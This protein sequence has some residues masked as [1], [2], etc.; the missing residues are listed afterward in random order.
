MKQHKKRWAAH[1]IIALLAMFV[2]YA[3]TR[4]Q[5]LPNDATGTWLELVSDNALSKKWSIP[6]VGVLRQYDLGHDTEFAFL[7]TGATYTLPNAN[8]KATLGAAYL[9]NLPFDQELFRPEQYQFWVY[10]ELTIINAD[11]WSQRFRLEHR[12]IHDTERIYIGHRLRYRLQF[13]STFAHNFYFKCF[14]EP[15]FNFR[16]ANIDQ[17]RFFIGLGSRLAANISVEVGY[18]KHHVGKSNYDR[19]R[20]ALFLKT[21]LFNKTPDLV[22]TDT[23]LSISK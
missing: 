16:E 19:V 17:N 4:S 5:Q 11:Q 6:V 14:D 10:E 9:N 12:W 2:L 18:M 20:M 22:D 1:R 8:L 3:G 23:E 21:R 7:R 13:Q 15:F